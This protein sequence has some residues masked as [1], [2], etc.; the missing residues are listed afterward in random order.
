VR[1]LVGT[2]SLTLDQ[3]WPRSKPCVSSLPPRRP[4]GAGAGRGQAAGGGKPDADPFDH[5][6]AAG[7]EVAFFPPVTGRL[8][9]ADSY[10]R[11]P[12]RFSVGD[13]YPGWPSAMK[14]ARW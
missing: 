4:L 8:N 12:D 5:P 10:Y 13:E 14:T 6:L 7:D 11:Q 3:R 1:E 9:D 2:D